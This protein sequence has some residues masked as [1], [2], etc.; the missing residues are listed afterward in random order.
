MSSLPAP[1]LGPSS[2]QA[3]HR[4]SSNFESS[5]QQGLSPPPTPRFLGTPVHNSVCGGFWVASTNAGY[6]GFLWGWAQDELHFRKCQFP[7][8]SRITMSCSVAQWCGAPLSLLVSCHQGGTLLSWGAGCE[9]PGCVGDL[10]SHGNASGISALLL[11]WQEAKSLPLKPPSLLSPAWYFS[12][13]SSGFG[14]DLSREGR[15][16][17][18]RVARGPGEQ[19]A[20]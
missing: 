9:C 17:G 11:L 4:C 1:G 10:H 6:L 3:W 8:G 20:D 14:I 7:H 19:E 16:G 13:Y 5:T 2:T 15:W 12:T 18:G